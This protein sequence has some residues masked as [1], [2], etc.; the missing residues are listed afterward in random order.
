[1]DQNEYL[2]KSAAPNQQNASGY[3]I[4]PVQQGQIQQ[5]A[6]YGQ[7]YQQ[8]YQPQYQQPY[9]QPMAPYP[10]QQ[11]YNQYQQPYGYMVQQQ[12]PA[13]MAHASA[14]CGLIGLLTCFIPLFFPV[15]L[16][17][18]AVILGLI[19]L[20]SNHQGGKGYATIGCILGGIA[21]LPALSLLYVYLATNY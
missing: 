1:M 19:V 9:Q 8:P 20:F 6:G 5:F 13:G 15:I 17:A 21:L 10:N 14:I 7:Q 16:S 3:Q 4:Q 18:T 2:N 12:Y 11:Y